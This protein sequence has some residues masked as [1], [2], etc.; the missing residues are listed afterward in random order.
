MDSRISVIIPCYQTEGTIEKAVQSVL[1]QEVPLE[2]VTVDDGSTDGTWAVLEKLHA[3]DERVRIVHQANAGVSAARNRGIEMAGGT[4]LFFLDGD[5]YLLPGALRTL[6]AATSEDIDI[7]CGAY[8]IRHLSSGIEETHACASGDRQ[9]I[10]ESLLRGDSA[11]NSMCARLYR[12]SMIRE[13]RIRAPE[14]VKVGED[15]LFNLE[16]FRV[17]RAWIMLDQVIYRYELGGDSAMMRARSGLYRASRPMIEGIL[18]F[19]HANHLETDLF[20]ATIDL[21]V[22][23]LRA[24]YGRTGAAVHLGRSEVAE[25]TGGVLPDRLPAK[26]KLYFHVLRFWPFL[27]I[28]LP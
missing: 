18:R 28:L 1:S 21:Y 3:A 9:V 26:Q 2:I 8:T 5:D 27:S 25:M 14:G 19:L 22:R 4:W 24:E 13:N 23:T 16:A 17:A 7:C 6:L 15:V 12:T 11:L 20:R 10:Y